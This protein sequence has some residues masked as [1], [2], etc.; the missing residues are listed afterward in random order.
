[1]DKPNFDTASKLLRS[2][3]P[4][5]ALPIL[6][7][8][9]NENPQNELA[10]LMLA[11]C[12]DDID[13]ELDCYNRVLIINPN[14][15][16]AKN[17]IEL[18]EQAKRASSNSTTSHKI[19][20]TSGPKRV[21]GATREVKQPLKGRTQKP[22]AQKKENTLNRKI[23]E[24]KSGKQKTEIIKPAKNPS[25]SKRSRK[26]LVTTE[27][28]K[29]KK[30]KEIK[31]DGPPKST[32]KI[33]KLEKKQTSIEKDKIDPLSRMF[34]GMHGKHLTVDGV[35]ISNSDAPICM[36]Y[37]S[38]FDEIDCEYCDF[39]TPDNCLLR[40]DEYLL[41]DINRF[42]EMKVE[43]QQRYLKRSKAISRIIHNELKAHGRP[44]HYKIISKI[45]ND[46]HPKIRVTDNGVYRFMIWHPNLFEPL[47]DGVYRAK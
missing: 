28:Q 8:L 15:T 35:T 27:D 40:L 1:M 7:R 29:E 36:Q 14:N 44:L 46:R 47:G 24:T 26:L 3:H 32:L 34:T 12:V 18:I 45:V 19:Q 43:R 31:N 5:K 10:W 42:N 23:K 21:K 30:K 33:I 16:I 6:A 41:D 11:N 4:E 20:D 39:F 25:Q 9:L 2:G 13:K 38:E 17:Y 37:G 22:P